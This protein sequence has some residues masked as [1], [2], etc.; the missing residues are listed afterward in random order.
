LKELG[1]REYERAR[2]FNRTLSVLFL[3]IDY[4]GEFNN[5]YSHATGNQVL[6]AVAQRL[7]LGV[8]AMDLA[9]RYG[10][11]EFV[12]LL[13]ETNAAAAATVAERM[14]LDV[15]STR[16]A[17][18][19]GDLSVTISIGAAELTPAMG[20]LAALIDAAN[21]AEHLA[22]EGGRNQ[23]VVLPGPETANQS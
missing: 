7:L 3:D 12:I 4:F 18:R 8:R 11:E 14:R 22:K 15:A 5:R 10:G 20:D 1:P 9:A 13:P 19:W 23:V 17:T 21:Q 2:R 6:H 16:V